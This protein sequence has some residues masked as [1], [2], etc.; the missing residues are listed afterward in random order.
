MASW[1]LRELREITSASL[2]GQTQKE[3]SELLD[4]FDWKSKATHYHLLQADDSFKKFISLDDSLITQKLLSSN[5]EFEIARKIRE[6]SIVSAVM[7][8]NTLPEVL[9][10]VL[11]IVMLSGK[12]GVNEV[13]LKKVIQ[14]MSSGNL[15]IKFEELDLSSETIYIKAFTNTLKHINL[16]RADYHISFEEKL[17]H[18]VR[19]KEFKYRNSTFSERK[20]IEIMKMIKEYRTKCVELGNEINNQLR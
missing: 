19:F 11:N 8:A 5:E 1:D 2:N 7:I 6:I 3:L 13:T 15:R 10:Q 16:V 17:F 12:F 9:A 18:G 4:S 20:D 14:A